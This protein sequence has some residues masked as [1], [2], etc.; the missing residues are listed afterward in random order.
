LA[1]SIVKYGRITLYI[2]DGEITDMDRLE[3]FKKKDFPLFDTYK[4]TPQAFEISQ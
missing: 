2:N 4:V 1:C 3:R